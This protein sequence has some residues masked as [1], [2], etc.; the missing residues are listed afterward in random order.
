[1]ITG[2]LLDCLVIRATKMLPLLHKLKSLKEQYGQNDSSMANILNSIGNI[3]VED[4]LSNY[5]ILFFRE[6]LRIEKYYLGNY[7]HGLV[8]TLYR[9]SEICLE[10]DQVA[11][12]SNHLSNAFA[13]MSKINMRGRLYALTLFNLGLVKYHQTSY[14][15]TFKMH[16]LA[17][18][19]LRNAVGQYHLD[20][21]EML[22]KAADLQLETGKFANAMDNYL[23]ALMIRRILHGKTHSKISEMLCKIRLIHKMNCEYSEVLNA[24]Q[25]ALSTMENRI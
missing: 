18:E 3:L 2:I 22:V 7:H 1:M 15:D 5:S 14:D 9:I 11:E 17:L 6:Q 4:D 12:A 10:N 23:E 24:F 19:E 21:A 13:I 20:V 16:N 25:Q 8:D